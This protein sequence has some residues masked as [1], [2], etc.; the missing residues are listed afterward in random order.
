MTPSFDADTIPVMS[1]FAG[2]LRAARRR[3]KLTQVEAAR[4]A[5]IPQ[6]LW[7]DYERGRKCPSIQ[8]AERLAEAVGTHLNRLV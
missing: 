7:S 6:P 4:R 8:Q 5:G 3:K 1:D 2:K